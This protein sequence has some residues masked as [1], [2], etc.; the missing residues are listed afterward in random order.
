MEN[1]ISS[2]V[3][4]F[5]NESFHKSTSIK[6]DFEKELKE[7]DKFWFANADIKIGKVNGVINRPLQDAD[8]LAF[9]VRGRPCPRTLENWRPW[10]SLSWLNHFGSWSPLGR[11]ERESSRPTGPWSQR[12]F[13]LHSKLEPLAWSMLETVY[14]GDNFDILVTDF[15]IEKSHQNNFVTNINWLGIKMILRPITV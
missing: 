8:I 11:Q 3:T 5:H 12:S 7:N 13:S 2:T 15:Y 14:V 10:T 4:I 1:I 6:L 9:L